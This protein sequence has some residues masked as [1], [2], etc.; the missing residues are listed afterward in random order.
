MSCNFWMASKALSL[1]A[2]ARVFLGWSLSSCLSGSDKS[3]HCQVSV[4]I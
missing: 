1:Y 2:V 3:F 4:I